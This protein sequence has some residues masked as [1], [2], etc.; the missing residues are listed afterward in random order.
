ML[1]SPFSFG[2]CAWVLFATCK[3]CC[4]T[5]VI[6]SVPIDEHQSNVGAATQNTP[7]KSQTSFQKCKLCREYV[8]R[9]WDSSEFEALYFRHEDNDTIIEAIKKINSCYPGGDYHDFQEG[10]GSSTPCPNSVVS[11]LPPHTKHDCC[12]FDIYAPTLTTGDAERS[13]E[14][15]LYLK[16]DGTT[17]SEVNKWIFEKIFEQ[18]T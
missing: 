3:T 12:Y 15:R 14:D 7:C 13:R 9:K 5:N 16:G 10:C 6:P 8:K 11:I 18:Q 2:F 4:T 1:T 17:G